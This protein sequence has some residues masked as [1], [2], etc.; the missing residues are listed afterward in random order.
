MN[1]FLK[2][3]SSEISI[4][5]KYLMTLLDNIDFFKT[6]LNKYF[7]SNALFQNFQLGSDFFAQQ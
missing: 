2:M 5:K 3:Y 7:Y 4:S 1:C 6:Q